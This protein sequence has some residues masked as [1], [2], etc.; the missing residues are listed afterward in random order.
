MKK[1]TREQVEQIPAK[2]EIMSQKKLAQEYGVYTSAINYW[3]QRFEKSG[4]KIKKW[5]GG[6]MSE[7]TKNDAET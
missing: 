1:L 6:L 7:I 4:R 5:N 2:L 3:V